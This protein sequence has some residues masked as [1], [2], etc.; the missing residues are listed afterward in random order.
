[1]SEY[2]EAIRAAGALRS[3]ISK[4]KASGTSASDWRWPRSGGLFVVEHDS[5]LCASPWTSLGNVMASSGWRGV[6][7]GESP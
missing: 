1:M 4:L 6:G 3:T 7:S 2:D 5:T